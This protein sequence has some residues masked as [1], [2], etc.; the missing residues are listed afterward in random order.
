MPEKAKFT[1]PYD[2][3]IVNNFK[4]RHTIKWMKKETIYLVGDSG[5]EH[6]FVRSA[7][8]NYEGAFKAWN[9][10]RLYLLGEAKQGLKSSKEDAK[11]Q[12][13]EGKW[14]DNKPFTQENIDYFR[15]VVEKG[16]DMY[17]RMVEKL[18]CDDPEKIENYPH[19]NPYIQKIEVQV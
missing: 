1:H 8:K 9:K 6:N 10:L 15:S 7:H 2:N 16:E 17:L 12:L 5:P 4:V 18:S 3:K 14:S 19:D 11:K 13:K